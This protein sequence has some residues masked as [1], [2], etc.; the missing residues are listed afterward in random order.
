[1]PNSG[2]GNYFYKTISQFFTNK[3]NYHFYYRKLIAEL[4]FSKFKEYYK[5]YYNNNSI[6]T[7]ILKILIN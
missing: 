6:I 4:I 1:M 7:N 5:I 3:E 2:G